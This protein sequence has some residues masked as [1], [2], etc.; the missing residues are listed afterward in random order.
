MNYARGFIWTA[1]LISSTGKGAE[2]EGSFALK[3]VVSQMQR[4]LPKPLPALP[5]VSTSLGFATIRQEGGKLIMKETFCQIDLTPKF[6]VNPIVPEG[7]TKAI[8]VEG[9]LQSEQ[10]NGKTVY[11]RP[12]APTPVG[13]K[14]DDPANDPLPTDPEDPR[15]WD[16]DGDGKLGV[17]SIIKGLISGETYSV[18]RERY[19]LTFEATSETSFFGTIVDRSENY[20]LAATNK[21]LERQIVLEPDPDASK[22]T[23]QLVRLTRGMDCA[24]LLKQKD[25]LFKNK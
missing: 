15:I 17:T 14:L 3:E 24:A 25:Q 10:R 12:E 8:I 9:E 22:S 19:S 1:I 4:V 11:T 5:L 21:D 2:I 20:I 6:P 16:E 7:L 13:V 18:R 23:I